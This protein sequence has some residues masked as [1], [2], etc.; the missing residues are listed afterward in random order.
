MVHRLI[1]IL[2]ATHPVLDI[3][4]RQPCH[5]RPRDFLAHQVLVH[6]AAVQA[7]DRFPGGNEACRDG[8]PAVVT[9]FGQQR[10]ER[11]QTTPAF[12]K[13]IA[14]LGQLLDPDRV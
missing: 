12:D 6:H 7:F 11:G 10:A 14:T 1:Q 13:F 9:G 3:G 5:F 4:P 2:A 8:G